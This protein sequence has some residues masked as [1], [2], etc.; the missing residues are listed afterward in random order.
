LILFFDFSPVF[1]T[2]YPVRTC[3]QAGKLPIGAAVEIEVIAL[4]G[5]VKTEIVNV[6]P[7]L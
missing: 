6:D 5:D 3:Y 2:N 4:T 7:K 1:T